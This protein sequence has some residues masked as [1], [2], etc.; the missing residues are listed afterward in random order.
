MT[1]PR[2][3]YVDIE[4]SPNIGHVWSLWNQNIGLAQLMES[5]RMICFAAKWRGEDEVLFY[6]EHKDGTG[7]MLVAAHQLLTEADIVVHFNGR[8]FDVPWFNTEFV[9]AGMQPPAPF[10]TIDLLEIAKKRFRFPSNKLDHLTKVLGLSGK[11]S[12][13]GH[14]LWVGC[15]AGVDE[16]WAEMESYN[17]QDVV[18]LEE[19][20]DTFLPW[21]TNHPNMR[22]YNAPDGCPNCGSE[23]LSKQGFA[24]T[25]V[26]RYQRLKCND[27]GGWF[28]DNKAIDRTAI[29]G[30]VA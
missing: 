22:L 12:N 26:S 13:S 5:G 20:H 1:A 23:N 6:S 27:C 29:R 18:V 9:L 10:Q 7:E 25:S 3:L 15:M 11:M 19:L 8:K 21:I 24:L 4:T 30:V 14:K 28:R 16:A 2:V 17:R